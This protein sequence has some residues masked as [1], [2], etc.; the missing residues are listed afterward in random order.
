MVNLPGTGVIWITSEKSEA[1]IRLMASWNRSDST[2]QGSTCIRPR[3]AL[4]ASSILIFFKVGSWLPAACGAWAWMRAL[5]S[6]SFQF[7]SSW[8]CKVLCIYLI[9]PIRSLIIRWLSTSATTG[10]TTFPSSC[11]I[12]WTATEHVLRIWWP[13]FLI[14]WVLIFAFHR[15]CRTVDVRSSTMWYWIRVEVIR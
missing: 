8:S 15:W 7:R 14:Q 5:Y 12:W 4:I 10:S 1:S 2:K 11:L 13:P 3:W 6:F 9:T